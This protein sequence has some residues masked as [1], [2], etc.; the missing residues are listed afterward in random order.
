MGLNIEIGNRIREI[1][2]ELSQDAFSKRLNVTQ[3]TIGR[4]EKGS[5]YPDAKFILLLK[6]CY[7][8]NPN[9]LISGE[10]PKKI[11]NGITQTDS[12]IYK[13]TESEAQPHPVDISVHLKR[14]SEPEEITSDENG[15]HIP[16][17]ERP[18]HD[19]YFYVTMAEAS[20][21]AGG[22]S[23]VLS[24]KTTGKYYAFRK[25]FLSYIASNLKNL[26]LMKVTGD[27]MEPK[28]EDG[29]TVMIDVGRRQIRSGAI[30]AI[31]FEDTIVI[32]EIEVL[33]G[34]KAQIISR[35]QTR[36][37]AYTTNIKD[38]RIIGQVIWADR[39]FIK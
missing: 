22:G 13:G 24:E 32:K 7:D 19:N 6:Q 31:G 37:P 9:W 2:G 38:I 25:N 4:Y 39:A 28:I 36:Y 16:Q 8:V 33:P 30:Y 20:L 10:R 34:G 5:R 35:N 23:F 15:I 21:S 18:S 12:S 29:D 17:W 27:S 11:Q 26:V 1:R 3:S 14:E